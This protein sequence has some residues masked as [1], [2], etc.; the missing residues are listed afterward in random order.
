MK[1]GY[2]IR[3]RVFLLT[4]GFLVL[5]NS[6]PF[7]Q[8]QVT[9]SSQEW[10]YPSGFDPHGGYIDQLIWVVYPRED[11]SQSLLALQ[12]GQVYGYDEEI[13][14]Y[15]IPD[16]VETPGVEVNISQGLRYRQF[17]LNTQKFPTNHTAYRRALAHILDKYA[18]VEA[19]RGG[20]ADPMDGVISL[21]N[22]I[23]CFEHMFS[24]H[25]YAKNIA[26]A[27]ATLEVGG[28]RDLDGD[29]WREYDVNDNNLW[30]EGIDIDTPE[31]MIY[32]YSA[33]TWPED[34]M[35]F[36]LLDGMAQCGL[37][38]KMVEIA[39]DYFINSLEEG[40][41]DT[42]CLTMTMPPPGEPFLLYENFYSDSTWNQ[43]ICRYN[44]TAFDYNVT[45]MLLAPTIEEAHGWAWNCSQLLYKD[46]PVIPVFSY[47]NINAFR[48]DIWE[49]YVAMQGINCMGANPWTWT[50]VRLKETAGGPFGY[51][52]TDYYT[53]LTEGMETT[54]VL[55]TDDKY[56][57]EVFMNLYSRLWAVDPYTWEKVPD[58]AYNWTIE[59]T[60]ASGDIHAGQ[61][62]TFYL[63]DN[64]TWHDGTPLTGDDVAYS[65]GMLWPL[66]PYYSDWVVN[67][68]RIDVI[69]NNIVEV[70]TNASGY[71][72][73][74]RATSP[75]IL[76][77]HIWDSHS[78]FTSWIPET[79][80]DL[81]GSGPYQ[82]ITWVP[83]ESII[84]VRNPDWHF[85][86][87]HPPRLPRPP[88]GPTI[89]DQIYR[90]L[91]IVVFLEIC[92][93]GC[94]LYR[95]HQRPKPALKPE[96]NRENQELQS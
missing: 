77:Q 94:L 56:T 96:I 12:A 58:L 68:Y 34:Q 46:M 65:L 5:L 64:V 52:P 11:M 81:T 18:C 28:F 72:E 86:I 36:I 71:F 69:G 57:D 47:D 3:W 29:G 19:V 24:E 37:P 84:L 38:G 60:I 22:P 17:L 20:Y 59:P 15:S 40:T 30:D 95:R 53:V 90:L 88:P 62:F 55:M 32:P 8:S 31:I 42:I 25:F 91:L 73:F 27:N 51:Y 6:L 82:W 49:G 7:V 2:R 44:S 92:T 74:A 87:E 78:N 26:M 35:I 16:L 48:T 93:L 21:A 4:F 9:A 39:Y 23:Y 75:Y 1:P 66:S 79:P 89:W 63:Y 43:L 50:Q 85:A 54:N 67:I 80:E 33:W 14:V 76:P 10:T 70:Y 45:Q 83:G 61:K 13:P 41:F